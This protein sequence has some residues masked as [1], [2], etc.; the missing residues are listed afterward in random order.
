MNA[1]SEEQ[2]LWTSAINDEFRSLDDKE[3]WVLD[4]HPQSK[5]LPTHIVLAVKRYSD[6][7]VDRFKRRGAAGGNHQVYGENYKE[8]Y[9]PVVSFSVVRMFLYIAVVMNMC[10]A[11]VDVKTAFLNGVLEEDIWTTSPRGIPSRPPRTYKLIKAIY[12]LKQAHLMWHRRLCKDVTELGFIELPSASCVFQKKGTTTGGDVFLLVY[13]DD[14]LVLAFKQ[15][16]GKLLLINW[17]AFKM[18]DIPT[19]YIY[20]WEFNLIGG[21]IRMV[22]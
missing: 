5:P 14:I 17:K 12:G 7:R 2:E 10:M 1:T 18:S 6:G 19:R 15:D 20:S 11:Q 9:A 21:E 3:T 16:D 4:D 8:T 22:D 13:V